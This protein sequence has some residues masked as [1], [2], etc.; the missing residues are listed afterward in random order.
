MTSEFLSRCIEMYGYVTSGFE[1]V[2]DMTSHI[3]LWFSPK[4]AIL[5]RLTARNWRLI[6]P[7]LKKLILGKN[8]MVVLCGMSAFNYIRFDQLYFLQC[9]S[10][11]IFLTN[12]VLPT[13][14]N[15]SNFSQTFM[16]MVQG[17]A[18]AILYYLVLKGKHATHFISQ[19][20]KNGTLF[21]LMLKIPS[22][23]SDFKRAIKHHLSSLQL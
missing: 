4:R 6:L 12:L 1:S 19:A 14:H 15:I 3:G 5:D 22:T 13:F 21:Q 7:N 10:P 18:L 17:I 20:F 16:A 23:P 11:L 9:I 8:G 2:Q